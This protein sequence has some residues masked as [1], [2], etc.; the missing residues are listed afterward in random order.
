M[1][2]SSYVCRLIMSC[3]IMS[4]RCLVRLYCIVTCPSKPFPLA[5]RQGGGRGAN[6]RKYFNTFA[7]LSEV[8]PG[9]SRG[10]AVFLLLTRHSMRASSA[11]VSCVGYS[12][13]LIK[14]RKSEKSKFFCFFARLFVTLNYV[15]NYSR[16]ELLK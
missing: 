3:P 10:P 12:P 15:L 2:I 16:S 5:L 7:F 13:S 9:N 4:L 14:L 6:V 11:L 8:K 1:Q